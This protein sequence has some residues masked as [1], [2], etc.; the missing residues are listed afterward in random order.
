M[1]RNLRPALESL[2][3]KM[4]LSGSPDLAYSLKVEAV[5]TAF[6]HHEVELALTITNQTG[7]A[8]SLS[9]GPNLNDNFVATQGGKVV[10]SSTPIAETV[11]LAAGKST[12]LYAT[13]DED[14]IIAST[15]AGSPNTL[16]FYNQLDPSD[17][18]TVTLPT[19]GTTPSVVI[20]GLAPK[21]S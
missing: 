20:P 9:V 7:L 12:T 14:T 19:Q 8:E 17:T 4:L 21:K 3:G 16:T 11:T 5:P 13:V 1:F 6:G 10:F 15:T 2:E 18:V